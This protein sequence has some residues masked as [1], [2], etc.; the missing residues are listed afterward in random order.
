MQRR[1]AT[2]VN[3]LAASGQTIYRRSLSPVPPYFQALPKQDWVHERT[4]PY[5]PCLIPPLIG[6]PKT[7][8]L[9]NEPADMSGLAL[10]ACN[11]DCSTPTTDIITDATPGLCNYCG[12]APGSWQEGGGLR[13]FQ[14]RRCKR[15][16]VV[17]YC[18][19]KCQRTDW[20][21]G[22]KQKCKEASAQPVP[23]SSSVTI[24]AEQSPR[25]GPSGA[26][27][28]RVLRDG[29][30]VREEAL[31]KCPQPC[32]NC[33]AAWGSVDEIG[34]VRQFRRCSRCKI[35]D[36]CSDKCQRSHWNAKH[37]KE[38]QESPSQD[39]QF[40]PRLQPSPAAGCLEN[41]TLAMN[42]SHA[43]EPTFPR[44]HAHAHAHAHAQAADVPPTLAE[45]YGV[46]RDVPDLWAMQLHTAVFLNQG[47]AAMRKGPGQSPPY[48]NPFASPP[49]MLVPPAVPPP[50]REFLAP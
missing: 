1:D 6:S 36:Y 30:I 23:P 46:R 10:W 44:A 17:D 27:A 31:A 35:A 21:A 32:F 34:N 24:I 48:Y 15:C 49:N 4:A 12:A 11:R 40:S 14:F 8:M 42:P 37:K 3:P 38:C 13:Q 22:H 47:T 41:T 25:S 20:H 18:S 45:A 9:E 43:Q 7:P 50:F 19:E 26:P 39:R 16:K 33:G 29:A 2:H 5:S 28:N